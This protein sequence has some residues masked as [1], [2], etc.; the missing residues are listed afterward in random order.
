MR[1]RLLF[2]LDIALGVLALLLATAFRFE[3]LVPP[4]PYPGV[5]GWYL[6]CTLPLKALCYIGVGLYRRMWRFAGMVDFERLLVAT[7]L[8]AVIGLIAGAWALP[9]L[10]IIP[11]RV[12]LSILALDALLTVAFVAAPRFLTRLLTRRAMQA[13]SSQP[14]RRVLIVGAGSAGDLVS[15]DLLSHPS[16]GLLPVGFLDDAREKQGLRLQGLPV[17][18]QLDELEKVAAD[19]GVDEVIIAMPS[20]PGSIIRAVVETAS[21]AKLPARTVPSMKEV[22]S[23]RLRATSLRPVQIEDLLRRAPI[24]TDLDLVR[25]LIR[26]R[27][28]LVTGAGGSIG[29]ELCRQIADF[30]P[31]RLVLLGHGE[32]S[33][34]KIHAELSQHMPAGVVVPVLADVRDRTRMRDVMRTHRPAIVFHAA[35]HKHVP[36]MEW[37]IAEAVTNNVIG[38]RNVVEAAAEANVAQFVLVS[39]D[40]AVRP[41]SVMGATKRVAEQLVQEVGEAGGRNFFSVRFGNVL[42]SRGSVVPNF[43][44]QI[45]GGGPVTV[46][47]PEM[48]RYFMTIPEAVQLVLQAAV[49]GRGG[50]VFVLDMGEPVKIVDLARD[51]IRLSGLEVGKDIEIKFT[52]VRPGEKLYEE[53]FFGAEMATPTTHPKVLRARHESLMAELSSNVEALYVAAKEGTDSEMRTIL[54]DMV[55]DYTPEVAATVPPAS[56]RLPAPR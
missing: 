14:P 47:H 55:P 38:T 20:A 50:D 15:R 16:T 52:G 13:I 41:T 40:K 24:K 37:N 34:F 6:F 18:G 49:L 48:R 53:L 7:G 22:L 35:A 54:M 17:L 56:S 45:A 29:S 3:S 31:S 4:D 32:N 46:T 8:A 42:G 12:P 11:V 43:L 30:G 23:G 51:L 27:R 25:A 19:H 26:G 33:I 2:P 28:V 9:A 44:R 39:T 5:I 36:L 10:G 21:G 1:E